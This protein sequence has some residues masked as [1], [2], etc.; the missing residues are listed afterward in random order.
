MRAFG[1]VRALWERKLA[2]PSEVLP[3]GSLGRE[4]SSRDRPWGQTGPGARGLSWWRESASA[5]HRTRSAG[6]GPGRALALW[7]GQPLPREATLTRGPNRTS[8]RW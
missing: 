4:D 6:R 5:C 1:Q 8:L 2:G 7:T 3:E